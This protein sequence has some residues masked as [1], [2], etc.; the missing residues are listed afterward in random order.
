MSQHQILSATLSQA[1]QTHHAWVV[2]L[3]ATCRR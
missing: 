1:M 2:A 3:A